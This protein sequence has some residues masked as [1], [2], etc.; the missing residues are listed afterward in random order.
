MVVKTGEHVYR[1][2][3]GNP[4]LA[5]HD[6]PINSRWHANNYVVGKEA[7]A[8]LKTDSWYG[9]FYPEMAALLQQSLAMRSSV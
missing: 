7:V 8:D 3:N 9:R 2:Q 5:A 6:I 1:Y 4:E